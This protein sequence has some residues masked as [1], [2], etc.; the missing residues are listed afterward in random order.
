MRHE[1]LVASSDGGAPR[2]GVDFGSCETKLALPFASTAPQP[3]YLHVPT[4]ISYSR[5]EAEPIQ[6]SCIGNAAV[7]RRDHLDLQNPLTVPAAERGRVLKDF[8]MHLRDLMQKRKEPSAWGVVGCPSDLD[9]PEAMARR[10]LANELFERVVFVDDMF[11]TA[12]SVASQEVRQHSILVDVG[13]ASIRG[14]L[15][16]GIAPDAE[17]RVHVDFGC[18]RLVDAVGKALL[19]R[20]PELVLTDVTLERL[21]RKLAFVHP[22][23]RRCRLR[24][25]FRGRAKLI[26]VTRAVEEAC[27]R[28]VGPVLKATREILARCPSDDIESFQR[29][30]LLVGGGAH[31]PGLAA[32]VQDELR[33]DGFE[34][35]RVR[36]AKNAS[37]LVARGAFEWAQQLPPEEWSIPLFS[38]AE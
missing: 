2:V 33:A 9:G 6:F 4:L 18:D 5:P 27:A 26:D 21:K 32:R 16:Q 20:Y 24:L 13:H 14:V 12:L 23:R 22:A 35:A 19:L 34:C 15:M 7:D 37:R 3:H 1:A 36:S 29:H 38:F 11:L 10:M 25:R 28:I 30:I 31:I 17:H 8:A